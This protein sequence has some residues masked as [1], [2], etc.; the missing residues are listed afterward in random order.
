MKVKRIIGG[1]LFYVAFTFAAL[2]A[3]FLYLHHT[4]LQPKEAKLIKN[5][6]EHRAAFEKLKDMLLADAQVVRVADWGVETTKGMFSPV[7]GRFPDD[8][9]NQYLALLN[10]VGG[11]MAY[12]NPGD[13]ASPSILVFATGFGGDTLHVGISWEDPQPTNQVTSLAEYVQKRK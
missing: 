6:N 1:C 11:R 5:F 2:F 7:A 12:R 10:E 9:Y 4:N 13:H 8:R 3:F